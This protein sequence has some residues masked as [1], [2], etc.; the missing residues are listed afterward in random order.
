MFPRYYFS[1]MSGIELVGLDTYN[2]DL[3]RLDEQAMR[4]AAVERAAKGDRNQVRQQA[5]VR[6]PLWTLL[7][8]LLPRRTVA[9]R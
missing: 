3:K 1:E 4:A 6:Q 8:S 2:R 5:K 7:S 9:G